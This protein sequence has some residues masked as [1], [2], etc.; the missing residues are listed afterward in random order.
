MIFHVQ[1]S[2]LTLGNCVAFMNCSA[3]VVLSLEDME[4]SRQMNELGLPV[5]FSTK[6]EASSYSF[7][8]FMQ[9]LI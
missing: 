5:S 8:F 4:L 6:K 9:M 2:G 3:F 1:V 7:C